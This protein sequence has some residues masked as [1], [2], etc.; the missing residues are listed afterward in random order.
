VLDRIEK[1]G[2][3]GGYIAAPCHGITKDVPAE[4][5]DILIKTL[6]SQ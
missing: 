3:D 6:Q 1:I 4:N 5:I 2:K